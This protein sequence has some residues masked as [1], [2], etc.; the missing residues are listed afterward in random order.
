MSFFS[1]LS[2]A[3]GFQDDSE[4]FREET[5]ETYT[6]AQQADA[7][8]TA[9]DDDAPVLTDVP[10]LP[11]INPEMK[12][13]IFDGVVEI[14]NKSLPDFLARS[15]DPEAQK[16][17]LRDSIDKSVDDYLNG[18]MLVAEQYAE[19][20]LKVAVDASHREAE[21][22]KTD[23][24]Q[25]EQQRTSLRESQLSADRRRRA[26]ADRVKDL[27]EKLATA[28]A[29]REQFELENKSLV[30][31]LKVADI[32]PGVVDDLT[33]EIEDLKAQL[34]AAKDGAP[35]VENK[36]DEESLKRI[37]ELETFVADLRQQQELSQGMYNDLQNKLVAEREAHTATQ[38]KLAQAQDLLGSLEQLQSQFGMVEEQIRKRDERIEKLKTTNKRLREEI[39]NLKHR[40][41][42]TDSSL[43]APAEHQAEPVEIAPDLISEMNAIEDDFECPDW[44]VAE[45]GP[46][47]K[48]IHTEDPNFGYQE[49]E[50][51]PRK[52]ESDAQLSLF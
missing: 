14:F 50:P 38:E 26:L 17:A 12:G 45:P 40:I 46:G 5:D 41:E 51:K 42:E 33:K 52:P 28:E 23:M 30:N 10:T 11:E 4:D 2:R 25:L 43:F 36:P 29:E 3:L 19:A 22:L 24:A 37:A 39:D 31:K 15:V 21:K 27:E 1:K 13:R 32:Q 34:Q 47:Q 9:A 48:P 44:F 6:P 16:K 7:T 18:L 8:T 20:K 49:P 35:V